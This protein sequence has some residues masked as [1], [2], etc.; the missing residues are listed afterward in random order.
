MCLSLTQ[1]LLLCAC[2]C[3]CVHNTSHRPLS[4]EAELDAQRKKITSSF[5][6]KNY[7]CTSFHHTPILLPIMCHLSII[8][9]S[10]HLF[11]YHLSSIQ[12]PIHHPSSIQ[13]LSIYLSSSIHQ[14]THL[15]I[16][17]PSIHP[18]IIHSPFI[19]LSVIHPSFNLHLHPL[20]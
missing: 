18:S 16:N 17:L 5:K 19:H 13:P 14:S 15:S 2:V 11:I 6:K 8:H 1:R 9:P 12:P 20:L 10:F 4:S 7:E 3:V